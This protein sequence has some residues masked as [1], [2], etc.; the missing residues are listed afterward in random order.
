MI[1]LAKFFAWYTTWMLLN[2]DVKTKALD[3]LKMGVVGGR[4]TQ[5]V[6]NVK[7][8]HLSDSLH[9]KLSFDTPHD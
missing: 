5:M 9:L 3:V 1:D 7:S 6:R 8:I 4:V 2:A